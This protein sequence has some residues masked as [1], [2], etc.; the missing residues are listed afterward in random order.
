[1]QVRY[2]SDDRPYV[3]EYEVGD[4]VR[5][6]I[7]ESGEG[8]MGKAG[9]WGCVIAVEGASGA[10]LDIQLAGYSERR[11]SAVQRL[12]G[13]SR[14]I[15]V[16]CDQTGRAVALPARRAMRKHQ[17]AAP[18]ASWSEQLTALPAWAAGLVVASCTLLLVVVAVVASRSLL[19]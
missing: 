14:S 10:K 15:V 12:L 6:R 18:A 2:H 4:L 3:A 13:V 16:P 17:K 9:Q 8:A 19:P 1:M 11:S 7:S 5:L